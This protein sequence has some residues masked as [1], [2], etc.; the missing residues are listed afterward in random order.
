M[1]LARKGYRVLLVDRATFPSDT[2]STH[3]IH[4]PGVAALQ[5]W[6]LLDEVLAT[7]CPAVEGYSFDFGF[8]TIAG[9]SRPSDGNSTAY[10][11]RRT[12][13]DK[14]LVDA[15]A[16]AGVE[17]R[18][19][20][21]VEDVLVED[22][23]VVGIRGRDAAGASVVERARVVVGADGRNSHIAKA[24]KPEQYNEKPMLQWSYYTYWSG[25]PTSG[26]ETYIRPDRGWAMLPTNDDLT[27]LVLGWPYAEANAYKADVE[28]NYLKTLELA[29]EVAARV[30]G[31]KR[32]DRFH[33]GSVPNFFRKPYGPGWGL[34][35][36]AGYNKDPITA[37]GISD[38]FRDA[39]A[40]ST[41]LDEI[42]TGA[43]TFEDAMAE[44]QM[45]RDAHALP[46]YEFTTQLATMEA[47]PPDVQQVLL[48]V[49]RNADAQSNFVSM[50]AG[51]MSPVEFFSPEHLGPLMAATADH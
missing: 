29:P 25:L 21:T 34:I 39:E 50:V 13:L 48:A 32:E 44:H 16:A 46:I 20:F 6:G 42:F 35:G 37:Q 10:A 15:A 24:V 12:V 17:V 41:A 22:G 2:L 45:S 36:D 8:F 26:F 30:R 19:A 27:L 28:A 47:P 33:G 7:G 5:R 40:Y 9:T 51:T 23:A 4:A 43:R 38:A 14:I 3:L 11:P 18:E 49:S 31:A 1:L